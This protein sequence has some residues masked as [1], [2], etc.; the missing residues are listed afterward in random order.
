[1]KFYHIFTILIVIIQ[2]IG[3]IINVS[4]SECSNDFHNYLDQVLNFGNL[5]YLLGVY[6]IIGIISM[7]YT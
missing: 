5:I 1:M 6:M 3:N 7:T 4:S 2:L